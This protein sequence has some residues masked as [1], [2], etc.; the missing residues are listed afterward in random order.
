M[1]LLMSA[2][3]CLGVD[4]TENLGVKLSHKWRSERIKKIEELIDRAAMNNAE[5]L[6]LVGS[7]FGNDRVSEAVIDALFKALK[8][9]TQIKVLTFLNKSEYKRLLYRND[10]PDNLKMI[11]VDPDIT[12]R[13]HSDG[14]YLDDNIAARS[15]DSNI[16]IQLA[17]TDQIII[18]CSNDGQYKLSGIG[19]IKTVPSFE[20]LGFDDARNKPFGYAVLEFS[21]DSIDDYSSISFRK[22]NFDSAEIRVMPTDTQKEI[23]NKI[24]KEVAARKHDTFLR[25]TL[26]GKSPFGVTFNTDAL[27]EKLRE[28]MF[29]VDV[30][31]NTVMDIDEKEFENDISLRSEFVRLALQDESLSEAERNRIINCGWNA[32]KGGEVSAE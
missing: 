2:D 17:D 4:C 7:L 20:P 28:R 26:T 9:D 1:K 3:I 6:V 16:E 11:C 21:N 10:I 18:S 19:E 15:S 31:D 14:T 29:F 24:N 22:Y 13:N 23:L 32:L 5:Y 12:M 30:Y 27:E 8:N 25:I